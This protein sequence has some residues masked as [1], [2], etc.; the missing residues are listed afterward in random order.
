MLP[1]LGRIVETILYTSSVPRLSAWYTSTLSITPFT[2]TPSF[3]AFSLPN[4]SILLLFD[5]STTLN[6]K[7][8][9]GG[10]I[11]PHGAENTKGQHIAFGCAGKEELKEWEDHLKGKGV[12][13]EGR[14][15]WERGG[16]SIYFRDAEGHLLEIMTK[17][18]WPVY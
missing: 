2:S 1:R 15:S 7:T 5:R 6:T 13:V 10:T 12:Q 9:P 4:N 17:G 16:E 11:P 3:A 18:V 14:M 8:L